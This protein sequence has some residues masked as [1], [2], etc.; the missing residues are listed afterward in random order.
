V[1]LT[2]DGD[3]VPV[4]KSYTAALPSFDPSA[5]HVIEA[6]LR[7]P[8][9]VVARHDVTIAGGAYA[10]SVDSELTPVIV[11]G[12]ARPEKLSRCFDARVSATEKSTAFVVTV[13]DPD[14]A[15]ATRT[16]QREFQMPRWQQN[17]VQP[18]HRLD[19]DTS[20]SILWPVMQQRAREGNPTMGVYDSSQDFNA[21][22]YGM[23]WALTRA[24]SLI[25]AKAERRYT[26]AVAV[27]GLIAAARGQRR[28]VVLFLQP[29]HADESLRDAA[30]VRAYLRSIGVPLHVWAIAPTKEQRE[31]WGDI[32]DVSKP[33]RMGDATQRLRADLA[34]QTVVWLA[35]DP[36]H[37]LRAAANG[38][39]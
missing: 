15:V 30:T 23:L 2:V 14:G 38:C 33:W 26:D 24:N 9:G 1:I 4:D 29:G 17:T 35:A 11:N 18:L 19:R 28:A 16:F 37:A 22:T 25:P 31:A 7:F 34:S 32:A 27:A 39:H 12:D 8:S 21:N 5:P 36:W 20:E 10:G 13:K 3:P 6:Q